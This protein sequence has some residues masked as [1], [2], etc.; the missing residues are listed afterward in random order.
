MVVLDFVTKLIAKKFGIKKD[1]WD[2]EDI[3][4]IL[5]MKTIY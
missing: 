3:W 5:E 4:V 1:N 2:P